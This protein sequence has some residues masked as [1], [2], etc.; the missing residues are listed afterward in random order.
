MS[1]ES[2][3]GRTRLQHQCARAIAA[4]IEGR[5][6]ISA[7]L[8]RS[9]AEGMMHLPIKV[10]RET[11]RLYATEFASDA[12]LV[13]ELGALLESELALHLAARNNDLHLGDAEMRRHEELYTN[14]IIHLLILAIDR[15]LH[16]AYPEWN[17]CALDYRENP[18]ALALALHDWT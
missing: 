2:E 12:A 10:I 9:A 16:D 3:T 17:F 14:L 5:S 1:E 13:N 11:D 4:R 6:P 15:F 18:P 7:W 8:L